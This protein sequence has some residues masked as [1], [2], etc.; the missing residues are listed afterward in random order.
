MHT[1]TRTPHN[2]MSEEG[3]LPN[4][5]AENN[6]A[7]SLANIHL[8]VQRYRSCKLL[9]EERTWVSVGEDAPDYQ[10]HRNDNDED[11]QEDNFTDS[12]HSA[13]PL[14]RHCGLLVYV[15]FADTATVSHVH[16]AAA[17]LLNLPVLTLGQWGDGSR[18]QSV[19]DLL[20]TTSSTSGESSTTAN[21]AATS[22][23]LVPQANLF[24]KIKRHGKSIQY[25]RQCTS[26]EQG[27]ALF[28]ELIQ[29]VARLLVTQQW[30]LRRNHDNNDLTQSWQQR[31]LIESSAGSNEASQPKPH[32]APANPSVPPDQLFR[33]HTDEYGS[34][35]DSS[36]LPLTTATGDLLSKN[37]T[38]KLQKILAAHAKRHEKWKKKQAVVTQTDAETSHA[39]G[40]VTCQPPTQHKHCE[41]QQQGE[42][43]PKQS[44]DDHHTPNESNQDRTP[45]INFLDH[46]DPSF[47][48]VIAGSF[49]KRQGLQLGSDMGPFCHILQI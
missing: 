21:K 12:S 14:G 8:V 22:L 48:E 9:L 31:L 32:S 16:Q 18:P 28:D 46:L 26:K 25:S 20:A 41:D 15:S 40:N 6:P 17:T 10:N 4:D 24:A 37:A 44:A 27:R 34:W 36:G 42:A 5:N 3:L 43:N 45:G 35:D 1:D 2:I 11:H 13:T 29:H 38:K 7:S 47:C 30:N 33:C 49:G 23:V 19:L 39:T